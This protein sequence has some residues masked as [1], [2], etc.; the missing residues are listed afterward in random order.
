MV[1]S[2]HPRNQTTIKTM[3]PSG[4]APPKKAKTVSSAGKFIASGF[5]DDDGI[6]IIEYLLNGQ[7]INGTY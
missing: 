3:E 5:E 2:F 7:T 6:L 1:P 4:S